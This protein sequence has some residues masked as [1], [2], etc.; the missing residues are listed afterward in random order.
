MTEDRKNLP[1]RCRCG[2][3]RGSADQIAPST[4]FRFI[5]YCG[6]CQAFARFLDR[7][8]VLNAAG[9]TDIFHMPAG[10]VKLT[11]GADAVRCLHFSQ[12][13][14]RWY[15]ECCKT[16]L[17]NTAGPGF[18]VVGIIH[19]FMDHGADGRSRNEALGAPLCGIFEESATGLL[20]PDAPPP[21]SFRLIARRGPALI[22]WL[23]RGLGRPNPFFDAD[24]NAPLSAPRVFTPAERA[25]L[26][27]QPF[28][29]T[30]N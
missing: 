18:P 30:G 15:T 17:A 23:L 16:P 19:S 8:D 11:A 26:A 2:H 7:P 28:A 24:T 25:A 21:R 13:V 10:R 27:R 3:V 1:L 12:R 5:C 6:D 29:V 22:G 4:G 9:G 20:P 14:F